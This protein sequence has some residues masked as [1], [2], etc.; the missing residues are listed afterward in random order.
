MRIGR[1]A[2]QSPHMTD[3]AP[4]IRVYTL[5]GRLGTTSTALLSFL[6]ETRLSDVTTSLATLPGDAAAT[7]ANAWHHHHDPAPDPVEPAGEAAGSATPDREEAPTAAT[8]P[9]KG[10][11]AGGKK[12]AKNKKASEPGTSSKKVKAGSKKAGKKASKTGK[13]KAK[14]GKVKAGKAAKKKKSEA[15]RLAGRASLLRPVKGQ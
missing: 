10:T 3:T 8:K 11:K 2:E 6:A 5:A 4:R 1:G 13:A 7:I 14:T 9:R 15:P 12:P